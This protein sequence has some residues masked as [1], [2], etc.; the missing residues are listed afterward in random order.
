MS[1]TANKDVAYEDIA[2]GCS[3]EFLYIMT[4]RKTENLYTNMIQ[5]QG[6][7]SAQ[8]MKDFTSAFFGEAEMRQRKVSGEDQILADRIQRHSIFNQTETEE[9]KNR[10]RRNIFRRKLL[11]RKDATP[12]DAE[13]IQKID[14]QRAATEALLENLEIAHETTG[15]LEG[16]IKRV[17]YITGLP[18]WDD[19]QE[20]INAINFEKALPSP[21]FTADERRTVKARLIKR[22]EKWDNVA[23]PKIYK[24]FSK[25]Y[26]A[27]A[28]DLYAKIEAALNSG[29]LLTATS[30]EFVPKNVSSFLG[31][32]DESLNE[33]IAENHVYTVLG[34]EFRDGNRFIKLK[35]P[36]GMGSLEYSRKGS[37][38]SRDIKRS[39]TDDRGIFFIE[40]NDF[41]A[42]FALLS[43]N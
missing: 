32:N 8:F 33:G 5:T 19:V 30:K 22:L 13:S 41:M 12:A 38:Y 7:S 18:R 39:N 1:S 10:L 11:G 29:G 25:K 42:K 36:W 35:N 15:R 16:S 17:R 4:G 27:A 28:V 24:A 6:R 9:N 23:I 26:S 3:S 21:L 2:G 14:R 43:K 37:G 40:L 31:L 34:T 20:K